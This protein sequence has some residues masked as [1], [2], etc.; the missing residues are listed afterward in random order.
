[1]TSGTP[2]SLESD[3]L[4]GGPPISFRLFTDSSSGDGAGQVTFEA[5]QFGTVPNVVGQLGYGVHSVAATDTQSAYAD[6]FVFGS[7]MPTS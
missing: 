1:M 2:F 4:N 7:L 5:G 3:I 6:C